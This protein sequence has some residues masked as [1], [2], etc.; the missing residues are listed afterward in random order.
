MLGFG[1]LHLAVATKRALRLPTAL[2][3]AISASALVAPSA[4]AHISMT[5]ALMSRGGDEKAVP[6]D[7]K[8][9]DG[10]TYT[11]EPGTT[12]KL[13][14][15]E[16]IPHP[17]YF[18][19]AFDSDGDDFR[20]PKSIKPIDPSRA[21]PT[22]ENDKCGDS[23]FCTPPDSKGAVVLWD[24]LNP[25][26]APAA[27]PLTWTVTL[28]DV[29]CD[30]CT[31]QVLQIMEDDG[32]H[33]AYCPSDSCTEPPGTGGFTA[34]VQDIYHRCIDIKLVKGATNSPGATKDPVKN[35]GTQC[36]A[37]QAPPITSTGD[38][39]APASTSSDAGHTSTGGTTTHDASTG[40]SSEPTTPGEPSK[41]AG[42]SAT[43]STGN[44]GST[45]S[46]ETTGTAKPASAT[47]D[48]GTTK[49]SD[50]GASSDSDGAGADETA[51]SSDD[52]CAVSGRGHGG[53]SSL[54]SLLFALGAVALGRRRRNG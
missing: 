54:V 35:M 26:L 42:R 44:T 11:F 16:D 25:H 7:G 13:A 47:K 34:G 52:G 45:G 23:D 10:P 39:G 30:N 50:A 49:K 4:H 46:T 29:E 20:E 48:A 27:K 38:A 9:G 19:I 3:L 53:A 6:C 8:R 2:A 28:P 43:G 22:N 21:C 31:I 15:N 12:I 14:I 41:D 37:D 51:K 17:S 40:G 24:N 5:G 1:E 33:G 18:R 36:S 32:A